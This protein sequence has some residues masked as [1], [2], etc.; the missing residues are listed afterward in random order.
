MSRIDD[1]QESVGRQAG[2]SIGGDQIAYPDGARAGKRAASGRGSGVI[3]DS[4]LPTGGKIEIAGG[5][6][7]ITEARGVKRITTVPNLRNSVDFVSWKGP[8]ERF[9]PS[10]KCMQALTADVEMPVDDP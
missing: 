7:P 4:L 10:N 2:G 9:S 3:V 8:F 6:N 5:S 1:S